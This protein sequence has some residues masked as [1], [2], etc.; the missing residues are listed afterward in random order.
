MD[1]DIDMDGNQNPDVYQGQDDGSYQ[2]MN[3]MGQPLHQEGM[4]EEQPT[5]Q[6]SADHVANDDNNAHSQQDIDGQDQPENENQ[7]EMAQ[8]EDPAAN[9]EEA[10]Q[11]DG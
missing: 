10:V 2:D 7:P 6:A 11:E 9:E 3:G 5:M 4:E 8:Q 1:D